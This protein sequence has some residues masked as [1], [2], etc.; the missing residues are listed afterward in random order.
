VQP[1]KAYAAYVCDLVFHGFG[2]RILWGSDFAQFDAAVG[3]LESVPCLTPEQKRDIFYTNAAAFLRLDRRP[4][5]VE[6]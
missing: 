5:S 3:H 4:A 2:K 6:R 1:P